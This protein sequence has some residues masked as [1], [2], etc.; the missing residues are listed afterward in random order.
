MHGPTTVLVAVPLLL[1]LGCA[2]RLPPVQASAGLPGTYGLVTIDG[3]PVPF[4]PADPDRPANAPPGPTIV[5]S[6][7][8]VGPDSTFRMSMRYRMPMG[9]TGQVVQREFSGTY[10]RQGD[11][12]NF[13]WAGAGQTPVSLRGDTLTLNNMGMLFAY[14]RQRRR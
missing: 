8:T 12:Y 6:T 5:A 11:A 7:F 1:T 10:V 3:H 14:V 9:D 4:T 2:R 13:T